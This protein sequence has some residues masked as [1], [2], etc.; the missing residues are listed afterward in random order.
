MT[1][2]D[3]TSAAAGRGHGW[4]GFILGLVL[5]AGLIYIGGAEAVKS[6]FSPLI[7]PLSLYFLFSF[8]LF[9]TGS[10]RWGYLLKQMSTQ[11]VGSRLEI[12]FYFMSS[13]FASLYIP[14]LGSDFLVRPGL[15]KREKKIPY[16]EGVLSVF[17]EKNLD[18]LPVLIFLGP[19]LLGIFKIIA[20]W[21]ALALAFVLLAAVFFFFTYN[22][23]LFIRLLT[24]FFRAVLKVLGTLP[25]LKK[26][27]KP[28]HQEKLR[29]L[30]QFQILSRTSLMV[31]MSFTALRFVFLA[32]RLYFLKEALSLD[33][34][35]LLIL[36]FGLPVAQFSELFSFTPG[37]LG[38]LEGGWYAVFVLAHIPSGQAVAFLVGQRLYLYASASLIFLAA[39]ILFGIKRNTTIK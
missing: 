33:G 31:L 15:L 32:A 1:Q 26:L 5:F 4:P 39:Y 18:I 23:R 7:L 20:A 24:H 11:T 14:R 38:I 22:N 34:I 36:F 10:I 25:L 21:Q 2:I 6:N 13:V 35:T 3:Q 29:R 12:F 27:V 8:L 30:D 37:A 28:Q 16:K 9:F 19:A 17:I